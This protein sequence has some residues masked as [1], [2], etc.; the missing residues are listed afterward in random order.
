MYPAYGYNNW[1]NKGLA[2]KNFPF[3]NSM[4]PLASQPVLSSPSSISSMSMSM[5]MA[6]SM[7]SI[8][9]LNGLGGSLYQ[10]CHEFLCVPVRSPAPRAVRGLPGHVQLR[11]RGPSDSNPSSIPVFVSGTEDPLVSTTANGDVKNSKKYNRPRD[12]NWIRCK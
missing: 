9:N 4:S 2:P 12:Q 10:L 6:S 1:T 7:N 5:S 11:P 3:F 8:S